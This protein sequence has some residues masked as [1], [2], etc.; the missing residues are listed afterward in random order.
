MNIHLFKYMYTHMN[1]HTY[2]FIH[3]IS[4]M[5]P[6]PLYKRTCAAPLQICIYINTHLYTYAY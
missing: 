3:A 1:T 5:L 2:T 4:A 6:S